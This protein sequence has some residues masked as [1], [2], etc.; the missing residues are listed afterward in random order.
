MEDSRGAT[1]S[2]EAEAASTRD[3]IGLITMVCVST[4]IAAVMGTSMISMA[5]DQ[6]IVAAYVYHGK[7]ALVVA[8]PCLAYLYHREAF[9]WQRDETERTDSS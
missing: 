4:S 8:T 1:E 6:G 2:R 7:I 9:P 3:V 5:Q